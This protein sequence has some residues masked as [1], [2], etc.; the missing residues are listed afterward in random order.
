M[1]CPYGSLDLS[2]KLEMSV[3]KESLIFDISQRSK[4]ADF[5]ADIQFLRGL[6]VIS[7]ILWH[8]DF[9]L[10]KNGYLGVDIFLVI[11][12]YLMAKMIAG[13]QKRH[14]RNWPIVFIQRRLIRIFP[15]LV[16]MLT[17]IA[18]TVYW[19]LSPNQL[20]EFSQS[21]VSSLAFISNHYFA[22]E[23]DYFGIRSQEQFLLHTWSLG[24]EVQFYL[25][26]SLAGI[27]LRSR[28]KSYSNLFGLFLA[29]FFVLSLFFSSTYFNLSLRFAEMCLGAF[30]FQLLTRKPKYINTFPFLKE[31]S[32]VCMIGMLIYAPFSYFYQI[33]SV[34]L[35]VA[36]FLSCKHSNYLNPKKVPILSSIINSKVSQNVGRISYSLYL[37]H[38]P[39]IVLLNM[40]Y[41]EA[42][43][44]QKMVV[45]LVVVFVSSISY[46]KV[47]KPYMVNASQI[48]ISHSRGLLLMVVFLIIFSLVGLST[49]G[50]RDM[51]LDRLSERESQIFRLIESQTGKNLESELVKDKCVF[52]TSSISSNFRSKFDECHSVHSSVLFIIGDSHAM[53]IFN[54]IAKSFRNKNVFVVGLVKAGCRINERCAF[55]ED[56]KLFIASLPKALISEIIFHSA[57]H[58]FL[59]D[60]KGLIGTDDVFVSRFK[61]VISDIAVRD[62]AV[63]LANFPIKPIWLGPWTQGRIELQIR[64]ALRENLVIPEVS[65]IRFAVLNRYLEEYSRGFRTFTYWSFEDYFSYIQSNQLIDYGC[66]LFNDLDHLSTC[67]EDIISSNFESTK[68]YDNLLSKLKTQRI[69]QR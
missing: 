54:V 13:L 49:K 31:L 39:A 7:V 15:A 19:I 63:Y 64:G 59:L 43:S 40:K 41:A 61:T 21:L 69:N 29:F 62:T 2:I 6:A 3:S 55:L 10:P 25:F 5:R 1:H 11:S 56:A 33:I 44:Y 58:Y 28:L 12:G 37:W 47:E 48:S 35:L 51:Y 24:V 53:N 50:G 20:Y 52:A 65:R 22:H 4:N 27:F 38:Y 16:V 14:V 60:Y 23:M 18:P 46:W 17:F 57:G 36:L 45:I 66:V 26:L 42:T 9:I 67:H 34:N 68:V 30:T 8:F 32:L